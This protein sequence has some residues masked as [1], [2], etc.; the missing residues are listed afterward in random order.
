M[1]LQIAILA[2]LSMFPRPQFR[3]RI[4]HNFHN[5]KISD[6]AATTTQF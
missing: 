2:T 5:I 4:Y 3:H 6:K 1:G